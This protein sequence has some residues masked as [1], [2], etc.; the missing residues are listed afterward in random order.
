MKTQGIHRSPRTEATTV[1]KLTTQ[2]WK[3]SIKPTNVKKPL[4]KE[5]QSHTNVKKYL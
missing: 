3:K 1:W 4:S 2:T 5:L